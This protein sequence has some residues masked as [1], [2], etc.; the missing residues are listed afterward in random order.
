[1]ICT[2]SLA[3]VLYCYVCLALNSLVLFRFVYNLVFYLF[4]FVMLR[5][6]NCPS[7]LY[8]F[9]YFGP[10][11]VSVVVSMYLFVS[12]CPVVLFCFFFLRSVFWTVLFVISMFIYCDLLRYI[13]SICFVLFCLS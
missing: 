8:S 1:M 13:P 3:L 6:Y 9:V 11:F 10:L 2:I 7:G 12:F 4:L 5:P